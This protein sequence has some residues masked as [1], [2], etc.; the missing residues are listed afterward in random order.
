MCAGLIPPHSATSTGPSNDVAV[1][2]DDDRRHHEHEA[3]GGLERGRR[4]ARRGSLRTRSVRRT[5]RA[6]PAAGRA[7]SVRARPRH[8]GSRDPRRGRRPSTGPAPATTPSLLLAL[9]RHSG[10]PSL[11]CARSWSDR[12]GKVSAETH[13]GRL[14]PARSAP[15]ASSSATAAVAM[16]EDGRR[17]SS[18]EDPL[19]R[20]ASPGSASTRSAPLRCGTPQSVSPRP[21]RLRPVRRTGAPPFA[22]LGS[23]AFPSHRRGCGPT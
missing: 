3:R 19:A 6:G 10:G 8:R 16:S 2:E 17:P 1:V 18:C 23:L 20:L 22:L 21:C 12:G 4:G 13:A 7:S 14:P 9:S 5:R 15:P 11:V